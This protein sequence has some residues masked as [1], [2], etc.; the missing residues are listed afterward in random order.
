[1]KSIKEFFQKTRD[2]IIPTVVLLVISLVIT[3]AL[4]SANM[5]TEKRIAQIAEQQ[6]QNAMEK[7][8]KAD[9]YRLYNSTFENSQV[10]YYEAIK[11]NQTKGYIFITSQK[12]YGGEV[13]VMTAVNTSGEIAAIKVIDAANETPGLGQNATKD[14][15]AQKFKGISG[16]VSIVKNGA[17]SQK[18]EI[19]ALT[20]ATITSRAVEGAVNK[21]L[22]MAQIII[23][24][25]AE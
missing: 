23:Q 17:D 21:A 24:G 8:I 19:D 16:G 6:K 4:S 3:L 12:G 15:F 22:N 9:E 13:S 7:L 18:G 1:M 5:L 11:N 25:G 14:T 10:E 20:G 2:I